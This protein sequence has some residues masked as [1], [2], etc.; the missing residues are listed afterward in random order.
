MSH[1]LPDSKVLKEDLRNHI[2]PSEIKYCISI[3]SF[4]TCLVLGHK[5]FYLFE[6]FYLPLTGETHL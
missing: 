2:H 3:L 5:Y 1:L 4:M 6:E